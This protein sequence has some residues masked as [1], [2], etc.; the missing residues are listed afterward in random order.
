MTSS[1]PLQY[2]SADTLHSDYFR[3]LKIYLLVCG[4]YFFVAAAGTLVLYMLIN[5]HGHYPMLLYFFAEV[6]I[7]SHPLVIC[8]M[9]W[10]FGNPSKHA[11]KHLHKLSRIIQILLI[12][13]AAILCSL[14]ICFCYLAFLSTY[15]YRNVWIIRIITLYFSLC[16]L[17]QLITL[18]MI[19][20]MI[21]GHISGFVHPAV[22]R[23]MRIIT[24]GLFLHAAEILI[25]GLG[26]VAP[27]AFELVGISM[28]WRGLESFAQVA[29]PLAACAICIFIGVAML[30]MR[31]DLQQA[32]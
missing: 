11:Q 13:A 19:Y 9:C 22:F 17:I 28:D 7:L 1:S 12:P 5:R 15:S 26:I 2:Q 4:C 3:R 8:G 24:A 32:S 16:G 23:S 10:I 18:P 30:W 31:H 25:V 20:H 14:F 27:Y 29:Y 21:M 6:F